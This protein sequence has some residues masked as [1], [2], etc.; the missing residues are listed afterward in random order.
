M[1]ASYVEAFEV[2]LTLY[3][4]PFSSNLWTR[5]RFLETGWK[6][7]LHLSLTIIDTLSETLYLRWNLQKRLFCSITPCFHT[8][9]NTYIYIISLTCSVIVE[10]SYGSG[11]KLFVFKINFYCTNITRQHNFSIWSVISK[12]Y[13]YSTQCSPLFEHLHNI[14][15]KTKYY[16]IAHSYH[17]SFAKAELTNLYVAFAKVTKTND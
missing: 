7:E 1:K 10:P 11:T 5:C 13:D 3:I 12:L 8:R 9:E 17:R 16:R 4:T 15:S 6:R 14:L 2:L